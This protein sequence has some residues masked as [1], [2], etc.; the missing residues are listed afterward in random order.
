MKTKT[1][2]N[3]TDLQDL[4]RSQIM[5]YLSLHRGCSRAELG[6]ATGL[7][8]ASI[9]KIV[10]SLIEF[11]AV[12]ETGFAEGKKGRRSVGLSLCYDKYK[13]LAVRLSWLSLELSVFD[14]LGETYGDMISIPFKRVSMGSMPAVEDMLVEQV[15]L[16]CE[17]YPEICAVG[18]AT[19]G[20]YYKEAG[21]ILLPPYSKNVDE[22]NFYPLK[23]NLTRRLSLPVF[24]EHDADLG[25]LGYWRFHTDCSQKQVIMNLLVGDGIGV[26]IVDSGE[27]YAGT[28]NCSSEMGHITLNYKGRR[29]NCGSRGCM[30]AYCSAEAMV[31]MALEQLPDYPESMLH[32]YPELNINTIFH[33]MNEGDALSQ[34]VVADEGSYLGH[35]II[36]L[37]HVFD[38]DLIIISGS[39]AAAGEILL[40]NIDKSMEDRL[41][42]FI[43][44]PQILLSSSTTDLMLKG[45]AAFAMEH[46][47]NEPTRYMGLNA[48]NDT[49]SE[50]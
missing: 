36:S 50:E 40:E 31:D 46:L 21:S 33:C 20:P 29:C 7:T 18:V 35:G 43:K 11:G 3:L 34:R 12:Y 23:E 4:N 13:I 39:I 1:G 44:P 22:R 5:H 49:A 24:M 9:T 8:L 10:R 25:A 14:F 30:N 48:E 15:Q 19:I 27:I 17:Q 28:S 2:K 47:L 16:L 26:G 6:E 41:S 32:Q 45:A 38:P 42:G 37:L